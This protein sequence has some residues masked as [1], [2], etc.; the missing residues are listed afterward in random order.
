M[1][2]IGIDVGGA[3]IKMADAVGW[4]AAEPFALWKQPEQLAGQLRRMLPDADATTRYALTM[5]GELAD[6]FADRQVG[7]AYIIDAVNEAICGNEDALRVY[8]LDSQWLGAAEAQDRPDDVAAANW[9]ATA[10]YAA[11]GLA[12]DE[13]GLMIDI[14]STTTDLIPINS[15]G[16][17]TRARTDFDRLV[18]NQLLYFGVG[19]TPLC[20]IAATLPFR[21]REVHVMAE[22]FATCDDCFLV[23]GRT[24]PAAT[25][26][27][28]ADGQPRTVEHSVN[29]IARMIG[30]D[31]RNFCLDDALVAA[32]S[33]EAMLKVRLAAAIHQVADDATVWFI[34]GHG[35]WLVPDSDCRRVAM[36]QTLGAAQSR[37]AP[38]FALACLAQARFA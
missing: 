10:S 34:A 17:T 21:G 27:A 3:N 1:R 22:H 18:Q 25:D 30:L 12:A 15:S 11:R 7:V 28:S 31:R 16:V 32:R 14:G 8:G 38:A 33:I 20:A 26:C 6:C 37:V 19:R 24:E 9:H 13:V 36:Q 23:L 2:W 5:T 4:T 29:R 35:D